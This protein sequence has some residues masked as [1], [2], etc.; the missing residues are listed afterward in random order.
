MFSTLGV[1]KSGEL[2]AV[3]FFMFEDWF[4]NNNEV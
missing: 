1:N 4:E 3:Q 2:L